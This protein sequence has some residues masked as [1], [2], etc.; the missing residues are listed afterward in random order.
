VNSRSSSTAPQVQVQ[1]QLDHDVN[2]L[3]VCHGHCQ[4]RCY[5][6]GQPG[7]V[8][9]NSTS[10]S[11]SESGTAGGA[12]AASSHKQ[13][14]SVPLS[15]GSLNS[16]QVVRP[17][18]ALGRRRRPNTVTSESESILNSKRSSPVCGPSRR[19]HAVVSAPLKGKLSLSRVCRLYRRLS[20]RTPPAGLAEP[21][22]VRRRRGGPLRKCSSCDLKVSHRL[23]RKSYIK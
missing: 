13:W 14:L 23:R 9:S 17:G 2:K 8:V 5:T 11:E 16:F 7:S 21:R 15:A 1:V 6:A 4:S 12:A 3:Q 10:D 18:P 22:S 19:I 20:S